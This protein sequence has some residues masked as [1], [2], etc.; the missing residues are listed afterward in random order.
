MST[1]TGP[2][3]ASV[4]SGP[5]AAAAKPP[6]VVRRR[7]GG[8]L[9][10]AAVA[11]VLLVVV[12]AGFGTSWYGLVKS[13]SKSTSASNCP[14]GVT[15]EGAGASFLNAVLSVWTSSYGSASGN[16]IGYT[17]S[18]AGAGIT[19]L[20]EKQ[21][22]FAATDEPLNASDVASMPGSVLTLPVTGGP[23][24]IIYNV[25]GF[26]HPLNLTANELAGIY[27]GTISN[28]NSTS[29]AANNPGLPSDPIVAIH[30]SDQAGTTYV[31]TNLL[32]IYNDTWNRSVGTTILP[33]PW[34]STP[35]SLA[36][37]G[38]SALAKAV[39]ATPFSIGY[40]DLPDAI[41]NKLATAGIL[42]HAGHFVPP[43]VAAT[44]AAIQNLSGQ[45]IPPA[46]GNWAT[47]SWV[48]SPGTFDY[49][50]ATLSYFLV[51]EDPS[52]GFAS[53]V[54]HAQVL[55]QWLHFVLTTG[56]GQ[57]NGVDYVNPP[58][59]IVAQDLAAIGTMEYQGAVIPTCT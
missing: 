34:P 51:L 59:D 16:Q 15:I 31:L 36:E 17:A 9:L 28:W 56:Q 58:A 57:S 30:R 2:P 42:N 7:S 44:N 40:V 27:L 19:S 22:D 49:P 13:S 1:D 48:N 5:G 6:V 33:T 21:V 24:T 39:A 11:I 32:S 55:L 41:N 18:G 35:H 10:V 25:P 14:R 3:D 53:S 46:T 8:G 38:N 37:K 47:V 45:P 52:L 54:Q 29:L 12:V 4:P 23:V 50:L 43:T 20:A 26:D